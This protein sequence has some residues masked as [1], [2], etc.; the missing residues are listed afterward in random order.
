MA[1]G[2]DL[3][4]HGGLALLTAAE[5]APQRQALEI[6]NLLIEAGADVH[7]VLEEEPEQSP[8]SAS[9]ANKPCFELFH[10]LLEKGASPARGGV[11][12]TIAT[13]I[14]KRRSPRD[15][16]MAAKAALE[17]RGLAFEREP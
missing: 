10:Q 13:A 17:A 8:L 15:R 1:N 4:R 9:L 5:A 3:S 16:W 14:E 12:E 2:A 6:A 11:A 7:Y